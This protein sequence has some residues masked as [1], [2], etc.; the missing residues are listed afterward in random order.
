MIHIVGDTPIRLLRD[1]YDLENAIG[2]CGRCAGS[3]DGL[4][5]CHAE[6]YKDVHIRLKA[7]V[8]ATRDPMYEPS[9]TLFKLASSHYLIVHADAPYE[10]LPTTVDMYGE[11]PARKA[12][13]LRTL[14]NEIEAADRRL[15]GKT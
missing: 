4:A 1:M 11:T 14:A 10:V 13:V 9:N 15:S 8:E 5:E 2:S 6:A 7:F 3:Q 12:T